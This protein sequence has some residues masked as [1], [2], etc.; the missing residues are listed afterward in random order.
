MVTLREK[1]INR[2]V[3]RPEACQKVNLQAARLP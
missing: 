1:F 2:M 3:R